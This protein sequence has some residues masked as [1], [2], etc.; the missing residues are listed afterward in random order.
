MQ[1]AVKCLRVVLLSIY[2]CH[3][4]LTESLL[5]GLAIHGSRG[6]YAFN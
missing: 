4:T 6:I 3:F 5:C 1:A 2:F